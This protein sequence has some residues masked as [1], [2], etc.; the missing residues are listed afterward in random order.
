MP[1]PTKSI[2]GGPALAAV[3]LLLLVGGVPAVAQTPAASDRFP[4]ELVDWVPYEGS[5]LFAGTGRD[6]WDRDIRERGFILREGAAWRLWYTG[7]DS[8]KSEVK[9]LGYAT[10]PATPSSTACGPRTSSS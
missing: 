8:T 4:K 7:Y 2:R 9:S 3:L 10:T 5:P 6:T 1:D